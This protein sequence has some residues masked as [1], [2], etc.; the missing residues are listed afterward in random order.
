M[1]RYSTVLVPVLACCLGPLFSLAC[2]G[3]DSG[4]EPGDDDDSM[5]DDDDDAATACVDPADPA[6]P[7]VQVTGDI[8]ADTTWTCNNIY[9]LSGQHVFV[10]GSVLTIEPGTR[11]EARDSA[12]LVVEKDARIDAVG[13][14]DLPIVMTSALAVPARG[15]WGGIVLLGTATTNVGMGLAEGFPVA[16]TYGGNNDAH[17]CGTL[18]YVRVEW[19]GYPIS[20]GNEL[21]G[22]TFYSCGS[23]TTVD[24]VQVHMG[25]DD[26]IEWFGGTFDASHLVVTGAGDDSFDIDQGFRGRLQDLLI[27]QDSAIGDN[28][29]EISNGEVFDAAPLT[30]PQIA[31]ATFIGAGSANDVKSKGLTLKE[32][33]RVSLQS[34]I[35]VNAKNGAALLTHQATQ[36]QAVAGQIALDHNIFWNNGVPAFVAGGDDDEGTAWDSAAFE[37]WVGD[38]ARGNKFVDPQIVAPTWG[39]T[40]ATPGDAAFGAGATLPAGFRPTTYAGQWTRMGRIGRRSRGYGCSRLEL[41][42]RTGVSSTCAWRRRAGSCDLFL[43]LACHIGET[44]E[45][46][47]SPKPKTRRCF[48]GLNQDRTSRFSLVAERPLELRRFCCT[49]SRC[50]GLSS[51]SKTSSSVSKRRSKSKSTTSSRNRIRRSRSRHQSNPSSTIL[52]RGPLRFAKLQPSPQLPLK[53]RRQKR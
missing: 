44:W 50:W 8:T 9:L 22:I 32:G 4:D 52:R 27:V 23:E 2:E 41:S 18:Q 6:A 13:T 7:I 47:S 25:N 37:A 43:L 39:A 33:T 38:A 11:I 21:N 28:G 20:E 40:D 1:K 53:W 10:R 31:N 45:S 17:N 15:D 19:A 48:P 30:H 35:F 3:S 51:A 26:G 46:R 49:R 16:P 36:D 34:S 12:A 42:A 5:G 24:H 29:F 14:A